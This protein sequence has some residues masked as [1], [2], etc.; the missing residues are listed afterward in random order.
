MK[1]A[2]AKLLMRLRLRDASSPNPRVETDPACGRAAHRQ[3]RSAVRKFYLGES[4]ND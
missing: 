3:H 4:A 1:S 2:I